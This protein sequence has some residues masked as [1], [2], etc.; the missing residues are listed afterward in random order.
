MPFFLAG[1]ALLYLGV[2][3]ILWSKYCNWTGHCT[4]YQGYEFPVGILFIVVGL[5]FVWSEIRRRFKEKKKNSIGGDSDGNE[6]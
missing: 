5:V 3:V 6:G 1:I 2:G 4:S